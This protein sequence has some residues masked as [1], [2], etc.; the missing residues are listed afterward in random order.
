[1]HLI[2]KP[3]LIA[4][5][6]LLMLWGAAILFINI[7]LQ[8][9]AV[10]VR[11][12]DAIAR[13]VG[14]AAQ[15]DH[16]YY[17]PWTGIAISRLTIPGAADPKRPFL[18]IQKIHV[19]VDLFSLLQGHLIVK[20]LDLLS[21]AFTIRPS[22]APRP[23]PPEEASPVEAILLPADHLP[24]SGTGLVQTLT[25]SSPAKARHEMPPAQ[26]KAFR[27]DDGRAVFFNAQGAKTLEIAGMFIEATPNG[28]DKFKG[29]YRIDRGVLWNSISPRQFEG[30]FEWNAGHLSL[31][32]IQA[33]L[34]DGRL[35]G[36]LECLQNKSFV[37]AG[38]IENATLQKLAS[39]AGMD[40]KGTQGLFNAKLSLQ[41]TIG[42]PKTFAGTAEVNLAEA[43]MEPIELIRQ[44]GD[45]LRVEE[46]RLLTLKNAEAKFKIADNQVV[47]ES[48]LLA[49]ENLSIDAV[50]TAGFTG[51]LDLQ[52]RLHVNEKLRKET[53]GLIGKNF[54]PSEAEGYAHMP[55]SITGSLA[56][57]KSD[58]LDKMVGLR[59]GQD[60]GGLLKNLL[61]AP[62]KPKTKPAAEATPAP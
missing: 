56:R 44:L 57:P 33:N 36:Q 7:Y 49:S 9:D 34:G 38:K 17:T 22:A 8:S 21:P 10:Q 4:T 30:H 24:Q 39:D 60:V 23:T 14:A 47:V 59:I 32:D 2:A 5:G 42:H 25:P 19:G 1:V 27:I 61:R 16:T 29:T 50:G 13:E 48:L 6:G 31:P 12:R 3:I 11:L 18:E 40:A 35:S 43:R 15:T 26:I 46:L 54:Q 62:Q 37:L 20:N 41:G 53:R 28:K 45:L 55:F 52:A 51:N 58:L